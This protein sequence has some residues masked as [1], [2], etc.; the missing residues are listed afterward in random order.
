[1]STMFST[2][3]AA[4]YLGVGVKTLQR[5]GREG[6]L[7]P[8]R[9]STGRRIYSRAILDALTGARRAPPRGG[10]LPVAVCQA[11]HQERI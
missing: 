3:K 4:A 1:M 2:G 7:K 5:W 8:E 11:Q 9:T 10:R 6:R